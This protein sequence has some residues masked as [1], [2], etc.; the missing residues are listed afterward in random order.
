MWKSW[1]FRHGFARV[2]TGRTDT[3]PVV[4]EVESCET[5]F[6]FVIVPE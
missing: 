3:F 4:P 6:T 2:A 1:K 5:Q